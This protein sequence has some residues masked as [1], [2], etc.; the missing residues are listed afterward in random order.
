MHLLRLCQLHLMTLKLLL[1]FLIVTSRNHFR[2]FTI[3]HHHLLLLHLQLLRMK[4]QLA[5]H[6]LRFDLDFLLFNLQFSLLNLHKRVLHLLLYLLMLQCESI[7]APLHVR[8]S[9]LPA[10]HSLIEWLVETLGSA[11]VGLVVGGLIV[12]LLH[13]LPG[14]K[15]AA[16]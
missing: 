1:H 2:R 8:E 11:V 7:K 14:R 9:A 15:A 10:L 13:L 16:H 5:L 4:L 3:L 12:A 6:F